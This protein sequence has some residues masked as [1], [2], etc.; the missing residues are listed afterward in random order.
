MPPIWA[1]SHG[2][3]LLRIAAAIGLFAAVICSAQPVPVPKYHLA[4]NAWPMKEVSR[5]Q[6]LDM[7]ESICTYMV[8]HQD[9]RGAFIDPVLG[10]EHQYST[11]YLAY[12]IA[13]LVHAGRDDLLEQGVR[14]MDHATACVAS[15]RDAIPDNHG[16]FFLAP[17]AGAIGL[18]EGHIDDTKLGVW[19]ERM[20]R[21]LF[22]IIEGIEAK[23]NNWRTYAM[24]GEWVRAQAGLVS[25]DSAAEFIEDGWL[26]RTQFE[27][28]AL[29]R[30]NMYQDW[31]GDPQSHAVE[32]VGRV[33]LLAMLHA[34]EDGLP[35]AD[36]IAEAVE[37]G[38]RA[39]LLFQD[40]TGQCPPNGRTDNHVFNDVLYGLCFDIMAERCHA[41][42]EAYEARQYRR[43]ADLAYLSIDRW[44]LDNGNYSIT[45]NHFPAEDRVGF[46]P[47]SQIGNYSGAVALHLAEAYHVRQT[48]IAPVFSPTEIGGYAVEADPRFGSFV[49]NAGGMFVQINLLGDSVPKYDTYWTPLGGVRFSR[50]GWDSRLGPSDGV[51]D[52]DKKRGLSF[53]PAWKRGRRWVRISEMAEH[54][55]G[56]VHTEFV[57]PMLVKFSVLY[58]PVT[59]VGGPSFRHDFT[60]TPDGVL[61][62]LSSPH[63]V[64]F[65]LTIP[66]LENDGRDLDVRLDDTSVSTGYSDGESRQHF[67][68]IGDGKMSVDGDSLKCTYGWLKPILVES[69]SDSIDVFVY[70]RGSSGVGA[71]RVQESFEITDD[72]FSSSLCWV[73][74]TIFSGQESAGGVG[75]TIAANPQGRSD[76]VFDEPCG[77]IMKFGRGSGIIAIQTDRDVGARYLGGDIDLRAYEGWTSRS[78]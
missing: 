38:T 10:R 57:H 55:R 59:G 47:A 17:L 42:G 71:D 4:P 6:L 48:E 40:P 66:V 16:E 7:V 18:F 14:A 58:S 20:R 67:L 50:G 1:S 28:I 56:T 45:K 23:T 39:S 30:W 2:P 27:R 26:K 29:D 8:E 37:R 35:H 12:A 53:G 63:D 33:N 62:S 54:Y 72:G 11:P 69:E 60:V 32:A 65:A 44:R 41:R 21:P 34:G 15:G 13:T 49:A 68:L 77:F 70:P 61:T 19:R 76:L 25:R 5:E 3:K 75:Q 78:L 24:R 22:D 74:G 51:Y 52:G 64:E 43:A 73:R 46:Q 9:E 36:A 31:N